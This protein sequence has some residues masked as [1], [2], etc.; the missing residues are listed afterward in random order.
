MVSA[1]KF[2][3]VAVEYDEHDDE[4]EGKYREGPVDLD[5]N[6][7]SKIDYENYCKDNADISEVIDFE[8]WDALDEETRNKVK[9][10]KLR[11]QGIEKDFW[12]ILE[13]SVKANIIDSL[14]RKKV[15]DV[16]LERP[17]EV[18]PQIWKDVHLATQKKIVGQLYAIRPQGFDPE[19][20]ENM[21]ERDKQHI[22]LDQKMINDE[23]PV[24]LPAWFIEEV[25]PTKNWSKRWYLKWWLQRIT[26]KSRVVNFFV[27][28]NNH[29]IEE[30]DA[31]ISA[32]A[33]VCALILTIPFGIFGSL[34]DGF[35]ASVREA[36]EK[37]PGN[38]PQTITGWTFDA[39]YLRT[40]QSFSTS[41]YCSMM[42]II[43]TSIYYI[44]KPLPGKDMRKWCR[45]QGRLLL[46]LMFLVTT[47]SLIGLMAIGFYLLYF[48]AGENKDLCTYDVRYIYYPGL[49]GIVICS[50]LSLVCV[51]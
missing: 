30:P 1:L 11:P 20:W 13:E 39:M 51:W 19:L 25:V 15:I 3:V 29:I 23:S 27:P 32:M 6:I 24:W 46:V 35:F 16:K 26:Y 21:N 43:V 47:S 50:F 38:P 28:G 48:S 40:M 33:L 18:D 36:I 9:A 5:Q 49:V 12:D 37:C 22:C 41:F 14:K 10:I 2:R 44:F 31:G 4:C 34:T 7:S 17:E 45:S 8:I 42:G